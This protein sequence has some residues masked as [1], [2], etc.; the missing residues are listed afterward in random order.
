MNP[1]YALM[2]YGSIIQKPI[3]CSALLHYTSL[4]IPSIYKIFRITSLWGA[5]IELDPF[6]FDV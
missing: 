4:Y 6:E 1:C 2:G 5:Y 3:T